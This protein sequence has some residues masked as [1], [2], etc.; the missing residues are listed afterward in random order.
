MHD[1]DENTIDGTSSCVSSQEIETDKIAVES[2]IR[3]SQD[4]E[5]VA[6]TNS[7][8]EENYLGPTNLSNDKE[9][10]NWLNNI[11][12]THV[13]GTKENQIPWLTQ[14]KF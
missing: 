13:E 4:Q 8:V 2:Y 6:C 5:G 11:L 9:E 14:Y 1:K 3:C 12:R 10:K 7:L